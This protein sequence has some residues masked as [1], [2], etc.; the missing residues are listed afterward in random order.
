MTV[1]T[2]VLAMTAVCAVASTLLLSA[3]VRA[4]Q[5]NTGTAAQVPVLTAQDYLDIQQ[6][7]SSY[8]YGL[9]GNTD[10][11]ASYANLFA[12]GAVFGRPRTEGRD[13]L[14][15]LAN[16]EPHGAHY[17]RHFITNHVIDPAPGGAV[18]KEYAVIIDIGENG[19][20]GRIFLG[21][22][23]DDEYVKTPQGWKFKSRTFTPSRVDVP[24]A[25]AAPQSLTSQDRADIQDLSARYARALGTCAAE[26]YADLFAPDTG[27][28]ASNIRGEVVGRDRLI[29]LVRSERQ[30]IAPAPSANGGAA[31]SPAAPRPVPTVVIAVS[32]NAVTGRADLGANVGQYDDEY[33]KTPRGWR[34]KS[35]TVMTSQELKA[36]LT[37]QDVRAIRRLSG[38]DPGQFDDVYVAGADG[39][40]RFRAS[41]VALGVSADGVTGRA[42]LRNNGGH[43]EDVYMKTSDGS[44]RFK[45]RVLVSDDAA[46]SAAPSS[47]GTAR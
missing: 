38:T 32:S 4:Q 24:G 28:F 34:F 14:A 3:V 46:G 26:E 9:D 27:Y 18:G 44:W 10:N 1:R 36:G 19:N 12:P 37:V 41:G 13:N 43:Y 40:K 7:V 6:L 45:S 39:V 30:C 22:R 17:V 2:R 15:A 42:Y 21:G 47:T 25:A 20:P 33:V 8:P 29:A 23:Y 5:R 16:R 35:R 31:A 11:G